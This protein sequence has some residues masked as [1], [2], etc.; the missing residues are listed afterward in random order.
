MKVSWN[1]KVR[2][3]EIYLNNEDAEINMKYNQ[4]IEHLIRNDK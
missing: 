3:E 1:E 4:K 2:N